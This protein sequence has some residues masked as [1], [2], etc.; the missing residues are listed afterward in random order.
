[1]TP[2]A[3]GQAWARIFYGVRNL[4][5]DL[6]FGAPLLGVKRSEVPGQAGVVN[7]DYSLYPHVFPRSLVR[8]DD[9]I[10]DIGVGKGRFVNWLLMLRLDN[11]IIGIEYDGKTAA[12]TAHRLR[13]RAN[14]TILHAD[15]THFLPPDGTLFFLFNPFEGE[16][17]ARFKQRAMMQFGG[18]SDVR[19]VYL[20]PLELAMFKSDGQWRVEEHEIPREALDARYRD[21]P[22]HCRYAVLVPHGIAGGTGAVGP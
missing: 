7:S 17:M 2:G 22:S 5:I 20:R 18:R 16:L 14:V 10:V 9:V 13:R 4:L 19:F 3:V 15:A 21:A 1:V 6:R 12:A 8:P 11:R